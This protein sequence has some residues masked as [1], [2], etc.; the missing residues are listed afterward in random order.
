M[1]TLLLTTLVLSIG[2]AK[3]KDASDKNVEPAPDKA[4]TTQT[5]AAAVSCDTPGEGM[6]C[7]KQEGEEEAGGCNKWDDEAAAV[8]KR[9]IPDNAVWKTLKVTG[10]TCGGCERRVIAHVGKLDNVVSVEADSELG[11]VRIA[12]KSDSDE[13]TRA[14]E[15]EI[16]RL[17]YKVGE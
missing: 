15:A 14:A 16:K 13:T 6:D 2:C 1:R 5:E 12:M 7:G 8:A 4:M 9:E 11:Q 17:G 10:M 3:D